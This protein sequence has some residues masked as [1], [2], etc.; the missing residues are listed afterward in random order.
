MRVRDKLEPKVETLA[1]SHRPRSKPPLVAATDATWLEVVGFL[2][3]NK[4]GLAVPSAPKQDPP[5]LTISIHA[6]LS[7][8]T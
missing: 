6:A 7:A 4:L 1:W 3:A 5:G 2:S 8:H